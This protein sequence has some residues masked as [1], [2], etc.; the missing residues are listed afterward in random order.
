MALVLIQV[1]EGGGVV[2]CGIGSSWTE[3]QRH[4][5]FLVRGCFQDWEGAVI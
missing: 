1:V 5:D 3:V 4:S 2:C